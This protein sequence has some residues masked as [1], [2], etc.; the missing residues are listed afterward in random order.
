MILFFLLIS[1]AIAFAP[2][3]RVHEKDP[4][5]YVPARPGHTPACATG[6]S[7]FCEHIETYPSSL[8]E[9]LLKNFQ[10]EDFLTNESRD[11]FIPK[12]DFGHKDPEFFEPS[13]FH[14]QPPFDESAEFPGHDFDKF[15]NNQFFEDLLRRNFTKF[16]VHKVLG[17][18]E[19]NNRPGYFDIVDFY[20][21]SARKQ[22]AIDTKEG[23]KIPSRDK[24][25]SLVAPRR[26]RQSD[27][28]AERLCEVRTNFINPQAG[29]NSRGNWMFIVNGN[30]SG[31]QLVRTETCASNNSPCSNL[32][33]L[34]NNYG[35]NCEQKFI[36][37]RLI[38]LDARGDKLYTDT[39]WFPSCC[40]C[41][42]TTTSL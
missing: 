39:F 41:T 32:C 24:F 11:A 4:C 20:G 22:R 33:Q 14:H 18:R 21:R 1:Y 28:F 12:R 31:T 15:Y 35:S 29:M 40:V 8:I 37:K 42:L 6:G 16:N 30:D 5:L 38:A 27:P 34:P 19:S 23:S 25:L 10:S 13:D 36:Q 26:K 9:K 7:T 17:E 2:S 3:G